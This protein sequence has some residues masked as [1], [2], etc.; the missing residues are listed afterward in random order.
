MQNK[1]I[2]DKLIYILYY[3]VIK[4]MWYD[5]IWVPNIIIT[6]LIPFILHQNIVFT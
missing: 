3:L 6:Y 1:S 4:R 2:P 5:M